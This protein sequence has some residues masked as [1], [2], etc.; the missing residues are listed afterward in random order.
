MEIYTYRIDVYGTGDDV[1][2]VPDVTG[3]DV[4]ALDGHVGKVDEATYEN[5]ASC[6][7]VDTGF[8]IFGK[9]RMLPAGLVQRL[10][11]DDEKVHVAMTKEQIKA[12]PDF[13]ADR[14]RTDEA[15]YHKEVGEYYESMG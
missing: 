7:V 2:Q 11:T 1:T 15:G 8:W 13:D 6:L 4:E 10:D 14:H 5:E 3:W 9:K 12:A